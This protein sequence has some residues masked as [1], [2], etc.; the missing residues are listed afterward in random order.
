LI[1]KGIA[2]AVP[3]G[4]VVVQLSYPTDE[5]GNQLLPDEY[6]DAVGKCYGDIITKEE[7]QL[8]N[9]R[10]P[11]TGVDYIQLYSDIIESEQAKAE[12]FLC[13]DPMRIGQFEVEGVVVADI[14]KRHK[15]KAKISSIISNCITLQDICSTGG[16]SGVNWSE[17]G[18]LGSNLSA[19]DNL[20]LP[21]READRVAEEI[22]Q[23][24]ESGL[25]KRIEVIIYG[26]GAYQDPSTGIYELADPMPAFGATLKLRGYYREGFKYKYLVDS[27]HANGQTSEEIEASLKARLGSDFARDSIETEGTT[28]RRVEDIIAS[29]ADLI[30]GSADAGTPMVIVKDFLGSARRRD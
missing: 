28:P 23:R 22:Q 21:P 15:T 17:W 3:R 12:V 11:I 18:V 19:G 14:H 4:E 30:S 8:L 16:L 26:D 6:G 24:V 9:F 1:L 20:K 5:V 27:Y 2:A 25:K 7:A 13:N 29:L 10:H